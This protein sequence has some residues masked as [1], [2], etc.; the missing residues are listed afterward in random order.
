MNGYCRLMVRATLRDFRCRKQ[1]LELPTGAIIPGVLKREGFNLALLEQDAPLVKVGDI[2]KHAGGHI[3]ITYGP[4]NGPGVCY[5]NFDHR[6]QWADHYRPISGVTDTFR[7][8]QAVQE[9]VAEQVPYCIEG[10]YTYFPASADI[11]QGDSIRTRNG[12]L[13][14]LASLCDDGLTQAVLAEP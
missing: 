11:R 5:F 2:I 10:R 13:P 14:V 9:L 6:V 8:P 7:R 1:R 4:I 12:L 3:M